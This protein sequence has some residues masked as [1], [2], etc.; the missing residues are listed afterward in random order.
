M[1]DLAIIW[2][3]IGTGAAVTLT[4]LAVLLPVMIRHQRQFEQLCAAACSSGYPARAGM[5]PRST[6][7]IASAARLPRSS[8]EGPASERSTSAAAAGFPNTRGWTTYASG[9]ERRN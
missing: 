9:A 3:V 2:T 8:G 5:N 1:G 6:P 4:V 7:P